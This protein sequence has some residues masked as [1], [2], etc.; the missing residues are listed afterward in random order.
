[1]AASRVGVAGEQR[2]Y[3]HRHPA[4]DS[5]GAVELRPEQIGGAAQILERQFEE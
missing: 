1:L 3:L 2:R 4:V 5:A